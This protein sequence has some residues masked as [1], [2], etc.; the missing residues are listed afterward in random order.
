[1]DE[2]ARQYEQDGC[3]FPV[4]GLFSD[5]GLERVRSASPPRFRIGESRLAGARRARLLLIEITPVLAHPP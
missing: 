3:V 4:P 2:W 5:Q 1:M